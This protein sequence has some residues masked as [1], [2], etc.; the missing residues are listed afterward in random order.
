MGGTIL[1][2]VGV[3]VTTAIG[4][5]TLNA[6]GKQDLANLVN[7]GG[8]SLVGITSIKLVKNLIVTC[9]TLF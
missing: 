4:E 2:M 3:S 9:K 5:K 6:F 1:V 7:V 8:L